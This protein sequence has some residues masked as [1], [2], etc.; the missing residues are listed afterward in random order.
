MHESTI[1]YDEPEEQVPP[2]KFAE[3]FLNSKSLVNNAPALYAFDVAHPPLHVK[4]P[5]KRLEC[6]ANKAPNVAY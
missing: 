2:L 6:P 3:M 4:L 5:P 1:P